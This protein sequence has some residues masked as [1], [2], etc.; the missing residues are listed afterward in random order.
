MYPLLLKLV[1]ITTYIVIMTIAVLKFY[2]LLHPVVTQ[3]IVKWIAM[4]KLSFRTTGMRFGHDTHIISRKSL[5]MF[6]TR[7]EAWD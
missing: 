7:K 1:N 6:H 4:E 5:S 2:R 3:N